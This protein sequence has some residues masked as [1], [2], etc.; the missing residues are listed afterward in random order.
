M[1]FGTHLGRIKDE[2]NL[3]RG[4]LRFKLEE[5]EP[6]RGHIYIHETFEKQQIP[7]TVKKLGRG[8]PRV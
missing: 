6:A 1:R 2:Q 5:L 4:L 7:S 3:C 8:L